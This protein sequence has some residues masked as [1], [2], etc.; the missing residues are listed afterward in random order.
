MALFDDSLSEYFSFIFSR[1]FFLLCFNVLY[2]FLFLWRPSL[3]ALLFAY[4]YLV[5][6]FDSMLFGVFWVSFLSGVVGVILL[7]Y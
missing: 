2:I 5:S 4:L 3:F 7:D 1:V 6:F